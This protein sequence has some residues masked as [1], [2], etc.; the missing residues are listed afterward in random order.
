[1]KRQSLILFCL[2][3]ILSSC[4]WHFSSWFSDETGQEGK[5]YR[6]DRLVDEF[7]SL[8]SFSALQRMNTEYPQETRLLIEDV[9]EIGHVQDSHIEQR[10]REFYLDSTMQVLF[11]AVHQ[12]F[13]DLHREEAELGRVFKKLKDIDPDFC[14]PHLYSQI[15]G[16]NQSIVVGDSVLGI[17]LDKYLGEDFPLY[18]KYY[19][20]CQRR[21]FKRERIVPDV[22]YYYLSN[23]YPL[24]LTH[25]HTFLDFMVDYGKL[26]WVVAKL[27]NVSPFEQAGISEE[28]EQLY[29]Q[30]EQTGWQW[31]MQHDALQTTDLTVIREFMAPRPQGGERVAGMPGQVG[32]WYGIKI[33]DS[34]MKKNS[35]VTIKDLLYMTDYRALYEKSAFK[36]KK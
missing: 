3:L 27:R 24:S 10:L 12:E 8:N 2:L 35:D 7:V 33:V 18:K 14:I 30:Y 32:I 23:E 1:M 17:S 25:N 20:A 13:G 26:T 31:I 21:Q 22:L 29:R 16:L 11:E 15:S 36:L 34:F 19:Y 4:Q 9:L 28:R 5:I 6:Y